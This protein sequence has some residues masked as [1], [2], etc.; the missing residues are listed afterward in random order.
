MLSAYNALSCSLFSP[1]RSS[2]PRYVQSFFQEL[3]YLG[4]KSMIRT[5]MPV[6]LVLTTMLVDFRSVWPN[7][8]AQNECLEERPQSVQSFWCP[9]LLQEHMQVFVV[10]FLHQGQ[11]PSEMPPGFRYRFEHTALICP[12][13]DV[14]PLLAK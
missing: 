2:F 1:R 7:R 13:G 3:M 14:H 9:G 6:G 11:L 10:S 8:E 12:R 5:S 4:S